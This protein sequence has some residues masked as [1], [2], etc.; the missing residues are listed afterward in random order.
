VKAD[1]ANA[2][3]TDSFHEDVLKGLAGKHRISKQALT[4]TLTYLDYIK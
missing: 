1:L 2:G 3:R 4:C